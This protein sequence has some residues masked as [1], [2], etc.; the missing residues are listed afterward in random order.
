MP[1]PKLRPTDQQRLQVKSLAASGFCHEKI[2]NFIGVRSP[3]T[4]RKYF[5]K[6]LDFGALEANATVAKTAYEMATSGEHPDMTKYWLDR[7]CWPKHPNISPGATS[8]PPFIVAKDD[9][10]EKP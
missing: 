7:R 2:A 6:E 8:L 9:A 1:R 5:R 3:K 10:L 4:L